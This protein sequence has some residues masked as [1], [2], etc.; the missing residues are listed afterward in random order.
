MSG[1]NNS[2]NMDNVNKAVH[3]LVTMVGVWHPEDV[4]RTLTIY[5][6]TAQFRNLISRA[7]E[8]LG[9][10]ISIPV[11]VREALQTLPT[12]KI[13]A[14]I[15]RYATKTEGL[16]TDE[17]KAVSKGKDDLNT[18]IMAEYILIAYGD[19]LDSV[20]GAASIPSCIDAVTAMLPV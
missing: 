10:R 11:T 2:R 19:H 14:V 20:H 15:L 9:D 16:T 7:R 17:E 18:L 4:P 13:E 8:L 12:D 5:Y 1:P 6:S 3:S